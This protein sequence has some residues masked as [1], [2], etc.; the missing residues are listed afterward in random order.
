L[1]AVSLLLRALM[2]LVF[3]AS[4]RATLRMLPCHDVTTP[5]ELAWACHAS[6]TAF[7]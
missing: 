7:D 3:V 1:L 6:C 5:H 4:S 2:R